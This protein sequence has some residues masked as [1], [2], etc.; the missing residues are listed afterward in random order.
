MGHPSSPD[1]SFQFLRHVLQQLIHLLG[2][3]HQGLPSAEP[4]QDVSAHL[5]LAASVHPLA[6]LSFGSAGQEVGYGGI[7]RD[8]V[9]YG[10][11]D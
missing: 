8:M 4:D 10:G 1:G 11:R 2:L 6:H 3:G 5:Q 9:G 7:W